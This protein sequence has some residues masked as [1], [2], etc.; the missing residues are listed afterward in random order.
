MPSSINVFCS[1]LT[2]ASRASPCKSQIGADFP[3]L[4]L[5]PEGK[6]SSPP[7]DP[8]RLRWRT[9]PEWPSLA[10]GCLLELTLTLRD[11]LCL[12][13]TLN[14]GNVVFLECVGTSRMSLL[15]KHIHIC[16]GHVTSSSGDHQC[17][18][19]SSS[20]SLFCH[21]QVYFLITVIS[22]ENILAGFLLPGNWGLG[23]ESQTLFQI[24]KTGKKKVGLVVLQNPGD[25]C[26]ETS[27]L[28]QAL[29]L[30]IRQIQASLMGSDISLLSQEHHQSRQSEKPLKTVILHKYLTL[31]RTTTVEASA[32]FKPF[33]GLIFSLFLVLT[34]SFTYH[35]CKQ[36]A[37][38]YLC[39]SWANTITTAH[40]ALSYQSIEHNRKVCVEVHNVVLHEWTWAQ[41]GAGRN[42]IK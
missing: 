25:P 41:Q 32:D 33:I 6:V 40:E 37:R 12:Y 29:G 4:T 36:D 31:P 34:K 27:F 42:K 11:R 16:E 13:F 39:R 19:F 7:Q 8:Q 20:N 38:P 24:A 15:R 23:S 21:L 18:V 14:F 2:H 26:F 5:P 17:T 3:L 9:T 30:Q 1:C 22:L 35:L 28:L 10:F